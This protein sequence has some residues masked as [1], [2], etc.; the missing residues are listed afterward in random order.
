M[1]ALGCGALSVVIGQAV[2]IITRV[3]LL[4]LMTPTIRPLAHFIDIDTFKTL[5]KQLLN[6]LL[7]LLVNRIDLIVIA[8]S[9]TVSQYGL[10]AFCK[11][12][13]QQPI[14]IISAIHY[15]FYFPKF[16]RASSKAESLIPV[17]Y[18]SL[19]LAIVFYGAYLAVAVS[20]FINNEKYS[21]YNFNIYLM[22]ILVFMSALILARDSFSSVI[23]ALKLVKLQ[24]Y[25]TGLA[26][27]FFFALGPVL[28]LYGLEAYL[29]MVFTF[30]LT[31]FIWTNY[32]AAKAERQT[33]KRPL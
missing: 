12:I 6:N 33:L 28:K 11:Q 3:A 1:L 19:V 8:G 25:S 23:L 16:C 27:V 7:A 20:V 32:L 15:Q 10:Y 18:R 9:G 22:I 30:G 13:I 2:H 14:A 21:A 5:C 17:F 24:V 4:V 26:V 31:A 29:S